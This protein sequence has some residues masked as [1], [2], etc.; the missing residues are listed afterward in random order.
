MYEE[1]TQVNNRRRISRY[2]KYLWLIPGGISF[3]LGTVGVVLPILPTVPF[4][5]F[6]LFCFAKGSDS[7]RRRFIKTALYKNHLE[8]FVDKKSMTLRSK[9]TVIASISL[10]MGMGF[11]MMKGA[12]Y[13]RIT[14]CVIWAIHVIYFIFFIE[15]DRK[16]CIGK[17]RKKSVE[18]CEND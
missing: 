16:T 11:Y 9:L 17:Y 7:V 3:C 13:G 15:T 4:Y 1:R 14:V 2:R 8:N 10:L 18:R 12:F 6:A 5:M